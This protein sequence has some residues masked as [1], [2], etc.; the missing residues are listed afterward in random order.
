M[1]FTFANRHC[2]EVND[3]SP[4]NNAHE[5]QFGTLLSCGRKIISMPRVF[6]IIKP[7]EMLPGTKKP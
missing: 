1:N 5:N 2:K 4:G 6:F 3:S 7:T